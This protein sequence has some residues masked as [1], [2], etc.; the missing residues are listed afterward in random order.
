MF[1]ELGGDGQLCNYG[2]LAEIVT[3]KPRTAVMEI[4]VQFDVVQHPGIDD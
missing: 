3:Q 4:C 2:S 1:E